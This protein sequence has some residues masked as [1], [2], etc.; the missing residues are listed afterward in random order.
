M[1]NKNKKTIFFELHYKGS[2]N[3]FEEFF[4]ENISYS[5]L[6]KESFLELKEMFFDMISNDVVFRKHG[7]NK[8]KDKLTVKA[9]M[10]EEDHKKFIDIYNNG[11]LRFI[12]GFTI[13]N[14][15]ETEELQET[16]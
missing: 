15:R 1:S 2:M 9:K 13:S 14:I 8:K 3:N 5:E 7:R 10:N 6:E 12:Y 4:G 16:E 11:D